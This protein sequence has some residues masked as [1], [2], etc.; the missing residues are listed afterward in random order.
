MPA[1]PPVP[2]E[3]CVDP[4]CTGAVLDDVRVG[5]SAPVAVVNAI[6]RTRITSPDST[7]AGIV[8]V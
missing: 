6:T 8:N 3:P 5:V 4:T 2:T 1:P 7:P